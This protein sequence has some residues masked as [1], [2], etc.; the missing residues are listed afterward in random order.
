MTYASTAEQLLP[1]IKSDRQ[2]TW[3]DPE[4]DA[5]LLRYAIDGMVYLDAILPEPADYTIESNHKR[6]LF[7]YVMYAESQAVDDFVDHYQSQLLSMKLDAE[8]EAYLREVTD[9]ENQS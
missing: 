3:A 8:R 6:L 7:I 4:R 2:M 1:E 9:A 5:R